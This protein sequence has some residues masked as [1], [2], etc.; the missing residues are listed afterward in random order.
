M[1]SPQVINADCCIVGGG[2]AGLMLA[3]LLTR[4]GL[5]AVVIEKHADFLRDFRGDTIHP[6]TL[7]IMH[8]LGLLDALLALP[9]QRAEKLQAEV[10]GQEITM[11]D[12]SRLPLRCRFIAFMP[13]W[14][15]LTF[16]AAQ[17]AHYPGFTLLQSTGFDDFLYQDGVIAG[18]KTLQ[19]HEIHAPLVIGADGRRSAVR[20]KAG[21]VG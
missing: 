7:E 6:S 11:A 15:F 10:G 9:H 17:A 4:A 13:Q 21:L 2:P 14:D 16:L 20:Q 1:P 19:G 12:F 3:Y 5:R 8:Q 18:V